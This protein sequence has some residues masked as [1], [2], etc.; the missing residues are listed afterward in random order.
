MTFRNVNVFPSSPARLR[1]K[2]DENNEWLPIFQNQKILK[3][4]AKFEAVQKRVQ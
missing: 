3:L 4:S 1:Q 2:S